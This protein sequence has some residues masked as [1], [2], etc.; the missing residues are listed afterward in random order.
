VDIAIARMFHLEVV[1]FKPSAPHVDGQNQYLHHF[2]ALG[3]VSAAA[4]PQP[5]ALGW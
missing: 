1:L 2:R 5:R 3:G 4:Q